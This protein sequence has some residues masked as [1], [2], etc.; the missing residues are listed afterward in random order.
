M[1]AYIINVPARAEGGTWAKLSQKL[2]LVDIKPEFCHPDRL[3]PRPKDIVWSAK[4]QDCAK[5]STWLFRHHVPFVGMYL[6]AATLGR[7]SR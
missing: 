3:Q 2:R 1:S 6:S 7:S 5:T 4:S